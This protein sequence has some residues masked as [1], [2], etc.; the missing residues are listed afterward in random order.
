MKMKDIAQKTDQELTTVLADT[1]KQLGQLALE[2]R[3]KQIK[4]VKQIWALKR[5]QARVLTVQRE[6]ELKEVTSG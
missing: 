5:T 1:Q 6:R 2:M 3:T 4:N